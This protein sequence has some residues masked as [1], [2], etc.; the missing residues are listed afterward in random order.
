MS[1]YRYTGRTY[2]NDRKQERS[3]DFVLRVA[4]QG[5]AASL[6]QRGETICKEKVHQQI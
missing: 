3:G 4:C 1:Y 2:D 5:P 6:G